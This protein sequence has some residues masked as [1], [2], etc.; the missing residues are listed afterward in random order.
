M[1]AFI[2][3]NDNIMYGFFLHRREVRLKTLIKMEVFPSYSVC[4]RE[5]GKWRYTVY[6]T[7]IAAMLV[8]L[9]RFY[10]LS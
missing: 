2:G 4:E 8:I 3:K 9:L 5:G 7:E 1:R 10:G 6:V